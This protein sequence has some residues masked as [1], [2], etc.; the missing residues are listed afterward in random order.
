MLPALKNVEKLALAL[1]L[2]APTEPEHDAE[3]AL[4]A[5]EDANADCGLNAPASAPINA[6]ESKS[7]TKRFLDLFFWFI[8]RI[9]FTSLFCK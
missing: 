1:K 8:P 6:A 4:T 9:T 2:L 5:W 3:K 7:E